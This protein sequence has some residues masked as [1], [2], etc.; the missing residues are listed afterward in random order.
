MMNESEI[1]VS[2]EF[3]CMFNSI[4]MASPARPFEHTR[5]VLTSGAETTRPCFVD[6]SLS[7]IL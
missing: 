3:S 5:P 7:S 4:Y 2:I 1:L 6:N